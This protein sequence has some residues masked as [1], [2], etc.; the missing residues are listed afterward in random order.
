[1]NFTNFFFFLGVGLGGGGGDPIFKNN[2]IW[3]RGKAGA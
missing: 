2:K 3:G 1:M